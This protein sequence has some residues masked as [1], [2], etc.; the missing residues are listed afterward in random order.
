[1]R[2]LVEFP[3]SY[4]FSQA[5]LTNRKDDRQQS[6]GSGHGWILTSALHELVAKLAN[7]KSMSLG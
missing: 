7:V 5:V 3:H 4:R 6:A 1:M 2:L